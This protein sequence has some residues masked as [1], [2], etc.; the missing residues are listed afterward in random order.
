MSEYEEYVQEYYEMLDEEANTPALCKYAEIFLRNG[1]I[2]IEQED[3]RV[4]LYRGQSDSRY[5]LEPS[6]FRKNLL[7]K[8]HSLIQDMLLKAP[9]EFSN[10]H[11]PLER[12]IK[13]QHYGL[14]TRL[15]DVTTNPL[16]ALYFACNKDLD[17]DGEIIVFYDYIHRA[18][19][20]NAQCIVALTEYNGSSERQM[21]G[22]LSE[23][24]FASP[25]LVQLTS[26]TH[27]PIEVS[28]NNERIK[29]Q[30]GA[31]IVAGLHGNNGSNSFQKSRFDLKPLLVRDF[32]DGLS[33][34]IIIP[35]EDKRR[36]LAEL[37]TFGINHGFLFPEL[38]HQ[39][40]YIK[41]KY[42]G[43]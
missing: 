37:E 41:N 7:H 1:K 16:V 26:I 10:F 6:V 11:N 32:N 3:S 31:F 30:H 24:G 40:A 8:E 13:M 25:E 36:L 4:L 29:R 2:V 35:K 15:L 27:I 43:E 28:Q 12:L 9:D 20:I 34:S 17:V 42:E 33:R 22:F 5:L 38:E 14:P 21:L 23:K 18:Y 19:E 39:A